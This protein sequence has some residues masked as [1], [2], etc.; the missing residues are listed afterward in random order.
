MDYS[1]RLI[2]EQIGGALSGHAEE[3]ISGVNALE[4]AQPGQLTFAEHDKYAPQ[5][6]QTQASAILVPTSF[7]AINDKNLLRVENP[8]L[9]FLK[10]M[11]LFQPKPATA[12]GV[13]PHAVVAPMPR[14]AKA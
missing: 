13:D 4:L 1:L 12:A 9:A 2:N 8:R 11:D 7:P 5:V 6:Q 3:R 10:V 14:W